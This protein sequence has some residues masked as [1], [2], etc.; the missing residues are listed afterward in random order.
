MEIKLQTYGTSRDPVSAGLITDMYGYEQT[1]QVQYPH[2]AQKVGKNPKL[3]KGF[4]EDATI[5]K[6]SEGRKSC[7]ITLHK[8]QKMW[9]LL[10]IWLSFPQIV[11]LVV[12]H[13]R[14]ISSYHKSLCTYM[15]SK[16][17]FPNLEQIYRSING[18]IHRLFN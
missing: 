6:H 12:Q 9:K 3:S 14:N 18:S 4:S 10:E 17:V 16:E 1:F 2:I 5:R 11:L 15:G 8:G 13:F 7:S